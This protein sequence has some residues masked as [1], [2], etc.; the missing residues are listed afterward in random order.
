MS[1]VLHGYYAY[2]SRSRIFFKEFLISSLNIAITRP[3]VHII[4]VLV[5]KNLESNVPW[6]LDVL[7]QLNLLFLNAAVA[8]FLACCSN[9]FLRFLGELYSM[10][11]ISSRFRD[12]H[13]QVILNRQIWLIA[14]CFP[15][16]TTSSLLVSRIFSSRQ[17]VFKAPVYFFVVG[18]SLLLKVYL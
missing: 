17:V 16:H 9:K 18:C 15:M 1:L 7:L 4:A 14:W 2:P 12:H 11:S 6:I 13:W 3:E 8:S 10:S 5:C